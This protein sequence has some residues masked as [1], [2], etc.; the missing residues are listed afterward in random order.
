MAIVQEQQLIRTS[1]A[2]Q[3]M[4][5][6]NSSRILNSQLPTVQQQVGQSRMSIQ[7]DQIIQPRM[8]MTNELSRMSMHASMHNE[9]PWM[10]I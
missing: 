1:T 10:S 5:H 3:Q 8:S 7:A 6:S 2:G 9:Q 4:A